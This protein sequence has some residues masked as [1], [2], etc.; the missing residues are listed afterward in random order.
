ML[1]HGTGRNRKKSDSRGPLSR[2]QEN[3][4]CERPSAFGNG[5]AERGRC[6]CDGRVTWPCLCIGPGSPSPSS[7]SHRNK[8][9]SLFTTNLDRDTAFLDF[10]VAHGTLFRV[11]VIPLELKF[12][13]RAAATT[14]SDSR[15]GI[16]IGGEKSDFQILAHFANRSGSSI[17]ADGR[18]RAT[19]FPAK[20]IGEVT[21]TGK[22]E[23]ER[24]RCEIV[25]ARG[26]PFERSAQAQ[27]HQIAMDRYAG[28]LLKNAG[29]MKRR[30]MDHAG[31]FL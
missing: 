8:R 9:R 1:S 28:S 15:E 22:P 14:A 13:T 10:P 12:S 11:H 18:W 25:R 7:H 20:R 17:A 6:G 27:P 21:V 3:R 31:N 2:A 30:R 26:Q 24:Q 29:E 5:G 19:E 16:V 4:K 23:F